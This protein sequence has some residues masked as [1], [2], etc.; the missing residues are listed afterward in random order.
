MIEQRRLQ[1]SAIGRQGLDRRGAQSGDPIEAGRPQRLL[2]PC[3][4]Q[5]AA[6][7]HHHHT[8]QPEPLLQLVDLRGQRLRIGGVARKHLDRHRA[9]LAAHIRPITSCGRSERLSRL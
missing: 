3:A 1:W 9:A 6:V 2:D 8:L 7:T 4:G 5:H